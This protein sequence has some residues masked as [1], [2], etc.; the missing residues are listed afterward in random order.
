MVGIGFPCLPRS[1]VHGGAIG[2]LGAM[3]A[4]KV[5]AGLGDPLVG[6]LLVCDL[7][8]MSFR[9]VQVRRDPACPVCAPSPQAT[10]EPAG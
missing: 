3:E 6:K 5:L 1:C 8:T 9:K 10:Q 4:I 7:A 2:S